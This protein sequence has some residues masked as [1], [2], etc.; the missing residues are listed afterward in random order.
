MKVSLKRAAEISKDAIKRSNEL[1]TSIK[2]TGT[3]SVHSSKPFAEAISDA[4][5]EFHQTMKDVGI[6]LGIGF[7]LREMI[8]EKNAE[9]GINSILTKIEVLS[10]QHDNYEHYS[11]FVN[12]GTTSEIEVLE[13]NRA[14]LLER[15]KNS[16]SVTISRH[17]EDL[18]SFSV[19]PKDF[20]DTLREAKAIN[21]QM[22]SD[23]RDKV[24]SL[25]LDTTIEIDDDVWETLKKQRIVT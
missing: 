3:L 11:S 12:I 6:L 2:A 17:T 24:A 21:R 14:V 20:A 5:D 23:L 1:R 7:Q 10:R 8:G 22:R 4:T 16:N 18:I 13:G 15:L 19:V 9:V 25:N